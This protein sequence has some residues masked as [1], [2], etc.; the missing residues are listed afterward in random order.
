MAVEIKQTDISFFPGND[1]FRRAVDCASECISITDDK[2]IVLYVNQ[3]FLTTYRCTMEDVLGKEIE[4]VRHPDY[5]VYSD[6]IISE[7][8]KGGWTGE[9]ENR[10]KDGSFFP[11]LLSTA[12]IEDTNG[13]FFGIIGLAK[14]ISKEKEAESKIHRTN[15][16]LVRH[17]EVLR[18][19][20]RSDFKNLNEAIIAILQAGAEVL[21]VPFISLWLYEKM[22]HE[23]NCFAEFNRTSD[24]FSSGQCL[25]LAQTPVYYNALLQKGLVDATDVGND[26]R[27]KELL[28]GYLIPKGIESMLDTVVIHKGDMLGLICIEDT[29]QR[30]WEQEDIVF[31][32][33]LADQVS[34]LLEKRDRLIAE[35]ALKEMVATK[36]RFFSII[37]HD[38]KSPFNALLGFSSL[39]NNEYH[40]IDDEI[41]LSF[42]RNIHDSA[43]RTYKLLENLLEWSMVQLGKIS[44]KPEK[45]DI[46]NFVNDV[47]LLMKNVGSTRQIRIVTEVGY[48]TKVFTDVNMTRTVLQNLV[49]NAVKYSDNGGSVRITATTRIDGMV[50]ISV[51]DT[52]IGISIENQ[53]KLF[54]VG[55]ILDID[56]NDSRKGTGLGLILAKEFVEKCKGSI[57]VDSELGKGSRFYFTLPVQ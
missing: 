27:T 29:K 11:I 52:G 38:L 19:L 28:K 24:S 26:P 22:S 49:T 43:T 1:I 34:Y 46:S 3:A 23:I 48:G 6:M 2:N 32:Q 25:P 54:Q 47:V 17:V 42:I 16:K 21:D 50:E 35:E 8:M 31:A 41:R 7:T 55:E 37:A 13:D 51:I 30:Q 12:K 15:H 44:Y 10:R 18:K 5:L 40:N 57:G 53:G 36:D 45:I 33:S 14:D 20:I 9:L 4:F 56:D 39:L